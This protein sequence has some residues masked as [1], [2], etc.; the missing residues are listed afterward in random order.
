MMY[1]HMPPDQEEKV[2][3]GVLQVEDGENS[4]TEISS[5]PVYVFNINRPS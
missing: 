2:E 3:L 4:Y 5:V 1:D